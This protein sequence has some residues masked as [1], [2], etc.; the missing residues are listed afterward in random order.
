[1]EIKPEREPETTVSWF[2]TLHRLEDGFLATLLATMIL[3]ACGQILLRNALDIGFT[4]IDPLLRVLVLWVGMLGALAASRNNRHI[5]ID[6]LVRLAPV[7]V[8]N[9]TL[10]VASL[11]TCGVAALIA[12]YGVNFVTMEW[13]LGAIAFAGLPTWV[14]QTVIPFAFGMIAVRYLLHSIHHTRVLFSGEAD[15]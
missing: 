10:A 6:I 12:W 1:M 9:A 7:R 15:R 4:W 8:R 2:R 3:L 11:L 14:P 13:E 5:N